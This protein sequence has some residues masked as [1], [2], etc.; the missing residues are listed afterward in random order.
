VRAINATLGPE[1]VD[2][3]GYD[4]EV[5]AES[6]RMVP[7]PINAKKPGEATFLVSVVSRAYGDAQEIKIPVLPPASVESFADDGSLA[8]KPTVNLSVNLPDDAIRE[9]GQMEISFAST[10]MQNMSEC[11]L[12]L[13]EYPFDCNEQISSKTSALVS[14]AHVIKEFSYYFWQKTVRS[15]LTQNSEQTD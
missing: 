10:A 2:R 1:R 4:V 5:P 6:R 7:I 11:L 9:F 12:Y 13:G 3:L 8:D 15:P 14:F